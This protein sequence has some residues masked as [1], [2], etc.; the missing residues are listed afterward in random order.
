MHGMADGSAA[1]ILRPVPLS[2]L[3]LLLASDKT[4][5]L[6]AERRQMAA[7]LV[8]LAMRQPVQRDQAGEIRAT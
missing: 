2:R 5:S 7:E 3:A 6:A 4:A 8:A 1:V